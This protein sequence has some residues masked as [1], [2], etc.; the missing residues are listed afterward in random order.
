MALGRSVVNGDA[1]VG[2]A[3]QH[4]VKSFLGD[5]RPGDGRV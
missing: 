1:A 2:Q 4:M 5:T 3:V